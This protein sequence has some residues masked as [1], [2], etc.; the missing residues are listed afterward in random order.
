MCSFGGCRRAGNF[1][2]FLLVFFSLLLV[3]LYCCTA[4][5]LCLSFRLH[6]GH[7]LL[8]FLV[9]M[10]VLEAQRPC[11]Y[12]VDEKHHKEAAEETQVREWEG[13]FD[14]FFPTPYAVESNAV[15][16]HVYDCHCKE[17]SSREAVKEGE[18]ILVLSA[19]WPGFGNDT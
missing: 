15:R 13:L 3:G 14:T 2:F 8:H 6:L 4:C 10:S 12:S 1:W 19:C 11:E 5:F 18:S 17:Q 9:V 7:N 16:K